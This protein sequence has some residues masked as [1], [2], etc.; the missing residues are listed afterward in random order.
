MCNTSLAPST[1]TDNAVGDDI[2]Q[3]TNTEGGSE[4]CSGKLSMWSQVRILQGTPLF[5]SQLL[6]AGFFL[7]KI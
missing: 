4:N 1:Q 7:S 5:E 3:T 6:L 2:V